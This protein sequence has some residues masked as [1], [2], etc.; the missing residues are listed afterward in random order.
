MH[1]AKHQQG[2]DGN[3]KGGENWRATN[4]LMIDEVFI[5]KLMGCLS[6]K[7]CLVPH[8]LTW[9]NVCSINIL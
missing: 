5:R 6:I 9:V 8:F 2:S 7:C 3:S 4:I 1:L